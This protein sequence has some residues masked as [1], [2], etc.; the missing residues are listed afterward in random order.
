VENA[1]NINWNK[2]LDLVLNSRTDVKYLWTRDYKSFHPKPLGMTIEH[3]G[4]WYKTTHVEFSIELLAR[5]ELIDAVFGG[6][7]KSLGK[8]LED[9]FYEYAPM[10]LVVE[11][12]IL[13]HTFEVT[14]GWTAS[15][16]SHIHEY[17][18]V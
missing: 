10:T 17:V 12:I 7:E 11:R 4:P 14:I 8:Q 1:S 6:K 15:L 3:G 13:T 18:E 9:V 16:S 2:F 5:Q